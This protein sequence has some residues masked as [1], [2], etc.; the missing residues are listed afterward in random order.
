MRIRCHPSPQK[1]KAHGT[2]PY[3]VYLTGS[4]GPRMN[5][6]LLTPTPSGLV[7]AKDNTSDACR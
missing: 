3:P 5:L 6:R 1:G 7:P 2:R 4:P